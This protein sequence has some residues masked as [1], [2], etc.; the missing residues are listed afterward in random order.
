MDIFKCKYLTHE[1]EEIMG[2]CLNQ[3]CQN[4]TQYCYLCLNTTHQ[5][6]F[7]DCIRFTKLILFMNEC[8]QVYNQQRKQIEKK[9][10][11]FKIIFIDQKK[12]IRKLIYW[13][14]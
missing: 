4:V 11:K 7:N 3:R 6:H 14:I 9:L 13:K 12:W 1:N 5:E 10:N 8:M 2:F